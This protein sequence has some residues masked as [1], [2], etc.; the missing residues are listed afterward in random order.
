MFQ[1]F[2]QQTNEMCIRDSRAVRSEG[3]G[4]HAKMMTV[5]AVKGI[6]FRDDADCM[7]RPTSLQKK[8]EIWGKNSCPFHKNGLR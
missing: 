5:A 2:S 7:H 3:L 8:F 4:E 1:G 6:V